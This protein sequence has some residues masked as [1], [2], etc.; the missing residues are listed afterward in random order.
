MSRRSGRCH[1]QNSVGTDGCSHIAFERRRRKAQ[2]ARKIFWR[3]ASLYRADYRRLYQSHR[4]AHNGRATAVLTLLWQSPLSVTLRR[5]KNNPQGT[6][7]QATEKNQTIRLEEKLGP[8]VNREPKTSCRDDDASGKCRVDMDL[9]T[10]Y[11]YAGGGASGSVVVT[12]NTRCLT[13]AW[14]LKLRILVAWSRFDRAFLAF[15][16]RDRLRAL[17][18]DWRKNS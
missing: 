7:N 13:D 15:S 16:F 2:R 8:V 14:K 17:L 4:A 11:C 5:H 12:H 10:D 18:R 9:K 1:I 6:K 3:R